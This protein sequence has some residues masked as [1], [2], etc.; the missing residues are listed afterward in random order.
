M[1]D[2]AVPLDRLQRGAAPLTRRG[3]RGFRHDD[4]RSA[5][6]D[7]VSTLNHRGVTNKALYLSI[8]R[9]QRLM[10]LYLSLIFNAMVLIVPESS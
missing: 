3:W 2:C 5:I 8:T 7:V 9:D 1:D 6:N 10:V 4:Q